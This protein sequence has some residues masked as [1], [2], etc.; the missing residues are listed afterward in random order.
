MLKAGE[1]DAALIESV[2]SYVG[3][4]RSINFA[5]EI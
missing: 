3:S 2:M 5:L 1:G 4:L